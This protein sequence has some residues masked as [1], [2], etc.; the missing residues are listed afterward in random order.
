MITKIY[1]TSAWMYD[2]VRKQTK[3]FT[4]MKII[5]WLRQSKERERM[6]T[7]DWNVQV[8]L[9]MRDT[10][11]SLLNRRLNASDIIALESNVRLERKIS[12]KI[13]K[14]AYKFVYHKVLNSCMR[15]CLLI[16]QSFIQTWVSLKRGK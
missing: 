11:K 16:D 8:L 7:T 12:A 5:E 1:I 2:N 9:D 4:L 15:C 3:D 13:T 10:A 14:A 6:R